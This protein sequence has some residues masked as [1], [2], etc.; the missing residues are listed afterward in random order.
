MIA[1]WSPKP[2]RADCRPLRHQRRKR[3]DADGEGDHCRVE[4]ILAEAAVEMLAITIANSVPVMISHH[5]LSG[6]KVSAISQAVTMALPSLKRA[7]SVS[8]AASINASAA[9]SAAAVAMA[10]WTRITGLNSQA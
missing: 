3:N 1:T 4:R 5:G 7:P 9:A 6:G 10:I 2:T 8:R